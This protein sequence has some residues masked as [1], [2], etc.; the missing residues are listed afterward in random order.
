MTK[1]NVPHVS[2]SC[3]HMYFKPYQQWTNKPYHNVLHIQPNCSILT[4]LRMY[5]KKVI[6][7]PIHKPCVP[8]NCHWWLSGWSRHLS[9]MK[10][11]AMIWRSWVRTLVGLNLG[12][13]LF[14]S[15]AILEPKISNTAYAPC[16][17]NLLHNLCRANGGCH[18]KHSITHTKCTQPSYTKDH[19]YLTLKVL[20]TTTDAQWEGMGDVG[21]AR[22]EPALLPPCPTIRVL[23]Y[24]N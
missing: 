19:S 7:H 9:D 8:V 13:I 20:V 21:V 16:S 6:M 3:S 24:S 5:A 22:Y 12:C 2:S 14:L 1:H 18:C 15:Q 23:S 11:T 4:E 10:C 17:E